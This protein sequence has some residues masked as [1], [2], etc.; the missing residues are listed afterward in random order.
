M[1]NASVPARKRQ[2]SGREDSATVT[3]RDGSNR[4]NR[5]GSS[6][7]QRPMPRANTGWELDADELDRFIS[8]QPNQERRFDPYAQQRSRGAAQPSQQQQ[9]VRRQQPTRQ[10]RSEPVYQEPFYDDEV[11]YDQPDTEQWDDD[12]GYEDG[13]YE[14]DPEPAPA[15]RQRRAPQQRQQPRRQ[16]EPE[17]LDHDDDL[18]DDPYVMDDEEEVAPPP[19]RRARPQRRDSRDTRERPKREAPSFKMPAAISEAA[20]VQDRTALIIAGTILASL[21]GMLIV[22]LT[23]RGDIGEMVFTHVNAN[24]E[25]ENLVRSEAVWRMPII[26]VAVAIINLALAWFLSRWGNFLPRFLLG[27]TLAVHF[28]VW[29]ALIAYFF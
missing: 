18:Y 7:Q 21:L 26:G 4:N 20:F 15:P 17:Y 19:A 2:Q 25:P 1:I 22:V 3:S 11:D 12:Y 24:G 28:V 5:A 29:V 10:M 9:P 6:Q 13:Y 23:K 27:G 8:D 14:P 16:P